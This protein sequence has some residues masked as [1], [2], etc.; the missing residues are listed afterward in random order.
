MQRSLRS[1][2]LMEAGMQTQSVS[3]FVRRS[4]PSHT[5]Q[6]TLLLKCYQANALEKFLSMSGKLT[7]EALSALHTVS[8]IFEHLTTYLVR[9][10]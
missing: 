3:Q 5:T 9:L 8:A 10:H 2:N 1:L 4:K 6:I 7:E